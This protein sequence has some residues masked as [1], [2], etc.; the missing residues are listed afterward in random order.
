MVRP[1]IFD[2]GS[3]V[4]P[5][6]LGQATETT[7]WSW[8]AGSR[9][10]ME[11]FHTPV[12]KRST[13]IPCLASFETF[14]KGTARPEIGWAS[15]AFES[16]NPK[17]G[18]HGGGGGIPSGESRI[19][20]TIESDIVTVSPVQISRDSSPVNR[21][22]EKR[23]MIKT[24]RLSIGAILGFV[25]ALILAPGAEPR[26][27][28]STASWDGAPRAELAPV[29]RNF[30]LAW[31]GPLGPTATIVPPASAMQFVSLTGAPGL[32]PSGPASQG[33]VEDAWLDP[34]S[35][36]AAFNFDSGIEII[37]YP[38]DRSHLQFHGQYV[39]TI[40]E[41]TER[42]AFFTVAR[43]LQVPA[44]EPDGTEPSVISW[45]ERG[46]LIDIYGHESQ[47]VSDLVDIANHM[48]KSPVPE[49]VA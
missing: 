38:D 12:R 46:Y 37:Y 21:Q 36:S 11:A 35:Q 5:R 28:L 32:P 40:N 25:G 3:R 22:P 43:G 39:E 8:T 4:G 41:G 27:D 20:M 42:G 23:P 33:H 6:V 7:C 26:A 10:L 30:T 18:N 15:M 14:R 9:L 29:G 2:L 31:E 45:I 48:E 44:R 17:V 16:G 1:M 19:R 34:G 49:N 13:A 47:S 24:I